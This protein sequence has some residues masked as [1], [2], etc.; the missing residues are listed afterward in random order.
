MKANPE[1]DRFTDMMERLIQIPRVE[2][3]AKLNADKKARKQKA[4]KSS[5]SGRA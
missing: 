2:I 1:Y 5:A 4:K 3:K